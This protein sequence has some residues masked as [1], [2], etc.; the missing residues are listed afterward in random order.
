MTH[1]LAELYSPKAAWLTLSPEQRQAFFATIGSGMGGLS[2]LGI[3][4]LAFG[5]T[6]SSQLH[7]AQQQFFA[8]WKF[9]D[10]AAV[11]ALLEAIAA[12]GWHDY[13]DTINAAG[14]ATDMNTHLAQLAA[15]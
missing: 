10:K 12:T 11:T 7:P 9:S 6:D 1:Y 13:F 5:Q 14:E 4:P 2:E 3:E 15:C 8:I